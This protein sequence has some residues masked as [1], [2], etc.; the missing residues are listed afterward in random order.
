MLSPETAVLAA[1]MTLQELGIKTEVKQ[2]PGTVTF[3]QQDYADTVAKD[4]YS[5]VFD[6]GAYYV[7]MFD[8]CLDA[9]EVESLS[10]YYKGTTT[11]LGAEDFTINHVG[12]VFSVLRNNLPMIFAATE[13]TDIEDFN[14]IPKGTH[15]IYSESDPAYV[16]AIRG[17]LTKTETIHPMNDKYVPPI[18]AEKLPGVCL[19]VVELSTTFEPEAQYTEEECATLTALFAMDVPVIIKCGVDLGTS[20]SVDKIAAVWSPATDDNFPIFIASCGG[21]AMQIVDITRNGGWIALVGDE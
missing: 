20:L 21:I 19:P 14:V 13:D 6:S 11:E 10:W 8:R 3:T 7:K 2:T 18:P 5:I 4:G 9:S 1:S 16:S 17:V 15:F 12:N